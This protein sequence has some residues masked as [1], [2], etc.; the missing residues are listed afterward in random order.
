MDN[1]PEPPIRVSPAMSGIA[2]E[3]GRLVMNAA[4]YELV[5]TTERFARSMGEGR[6]CDADSAQAIFKEFDVLDYG[7]WFWVICTVLAILSTVVIVV[8]A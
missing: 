4:K 2:G 1:E 5:K 3:T 7:V 6:L 8:T